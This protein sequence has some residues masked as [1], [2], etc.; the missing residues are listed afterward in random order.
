MTKIQ[1]RKQS[2]TNDSLHDIVIDI[3]K[4]YAEPMRAH[5]ITDKILKIRKINGKTPNNSVV[6][7]LQTSKH[8]IRVV[9]GVYQ[10]KE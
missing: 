5:D 10:Y 2:S 6:S 9:R 4:Q 1:D 7:I 3:L 8:A